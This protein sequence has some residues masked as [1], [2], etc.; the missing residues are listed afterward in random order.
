[1]PVDGDGS[2]SDASA[3][4]HAAA[5][6]RLIGNTNAAQNDDAN[7]FGSLVFAAKIGD[8]GDRT[9]D[10]MLVNFAKHVPYH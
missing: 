7:V 8:D 5:F 9:H 3:T 10:P 1:V 4:P 2:D 6:A